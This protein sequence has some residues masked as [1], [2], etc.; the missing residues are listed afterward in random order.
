[1]EHK[2]HMCTACIHSS[3]HPLGLVC[4]HMPMATG[5]QTHTDTWPSETCARAGTTLG[6]CVHIQTR[7]YMHVHVDMGRNTLGLINTCVYVD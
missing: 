1:M 5:L 2:R 3:R 4:T 7:G 6:M